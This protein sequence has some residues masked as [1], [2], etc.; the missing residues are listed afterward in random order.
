MTLG[1]WR[2]VLINS[3]TGGEAQLDHPGQLALGAAEFLRAAWDVDGIR[4]D[5]DD[6][7]AREILQQ[8]VD[9]RRI[10]AVRNELLHEFAF[11]DIHRDAIFL[12]IV[13]EE[14]HR[15][16]AKIGERVDTDPSSVAT[17]GEMRQILELLHERL[18]ADSG[19]RLHFSDR[20]AAQTLELRHQLD[21]LDQRSFRE[22]LE[23]L[24]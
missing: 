11:R 13:I 3:D 16:A 10:A 2:M 9:E 19:A 12:E 6:F 14:L 24:G 20:E 21:S 18:D 4:F 15:A 17:V 5:A 8:K 1:F 23:E 7:L 22:C